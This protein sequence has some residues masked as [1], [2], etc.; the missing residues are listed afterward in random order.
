MTGEGKNNETVR[1]W[2]QSRD[3]REEEKDLEVRWWWKK[4][5]Q[6]QQN[7]KNKTKRCGEET[8]WRRK[9]KEE[10]G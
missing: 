8:E 4:T 3:L 2:E 7:Q 10:A 5:K 1:A 9:K 6:Q